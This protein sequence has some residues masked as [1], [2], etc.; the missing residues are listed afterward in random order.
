[1]KTSWDAHTK[2]VQCIRYFPKFGNF[3]LSASIDT[4]I[5]LWNP[6]TKKLMRLYFL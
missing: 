5:K 4:K 2:G 3:L 1:M 6:D